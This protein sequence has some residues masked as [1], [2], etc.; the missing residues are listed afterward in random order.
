MLEFAALGLLELRS[1]SRSQDEAE[2]APPLED[3]AL[4]LGKVRSAPRRSC[5]SLLRDRAE[6]FAGPAGH[7]RSRLLT[8]VNVCGT[9]DERIPVSARSL[10]SWDRFSRDGLIPRPLTLRSAMRLTITP[11]GRTTACVDILALSQ[12]YMSNEGA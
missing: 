4:Y 7:S 9:P 12:R 11:L 3:I 10:C 6:L 1:K 2:S 5:N 8:C